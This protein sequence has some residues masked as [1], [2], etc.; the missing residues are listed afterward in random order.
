MRRLEEAWNA[1]DGAA[2]GEPFSSDAGLFVAIRG[3]LHTGRQAIAEGHQ[4]ILHTIYANSTIRYE[5]L[6]ARELDGRILLAHVRCTLRR[7]H[8]PARGREL[9]DDHACSGQARRQARDRRVPQHAD[10]RLSAPRSTWA[11]TEG[12]RPSPWA[13]SATW[14]RGGAAETKTPEYVRRA[15]PRRSQ[16]ALRATQTP[17]QAREQDARAIRAHTSYSPV[18]RPVAASLI[19]PPRP[20]GAEP[21][22][23]ATRHNFAR[24]RC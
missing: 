15:Q 14:R 13:L 3:D 24:T 5:V 16:V 12:I 11:G 9:I 8:W 6:R 20:I 1:A 17:V 19:G 21:S 4:Q 18:A 10:H 23:L 22:F 7:A 2:F